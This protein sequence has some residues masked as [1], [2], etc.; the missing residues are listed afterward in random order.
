[1]IN[2]FNY[3]KLYADAP[4][5]W[6]YGF[7]DSATPVLEG[8]NSLHTEVMSYLVFIIIGVLYMILYIIYKFKD[9]VFVHK[10]LTHG[11]LIE[12][13]WTITPAFVLMV[14]AVPSLKLLYLTD[15]VIDPVIT[16]KAIGH[17][18]YWSYEYSDF[19][20]PLQ[21]N[22]VIGF[23]SYMVPESDLNKGE[24]RLLETDNN[25]FLPVD[26]HIRLLLSS[27]DVLH[28]WAVP[29]LGIKMDCVPGRLNQTSMYIKREGHYY[30]QC[31]EICGVQHAFMPIHVHAV[32]QNQYNIELGLLAHDSNF[33]LAETKTPL[34]E[35]IETDKSSQI[36]KT[37]QTLLP[38]TN[39]TTLTEKEQQEVDKVMEMVQERYVEGYAEWK[40]NNS[41]SSNKKV[42]YENSIEAVE[43]GEKHYTIQFIEEEN[44]EFKNIYQFS[45]VFRD[46]FQRE[47]RIW[48][49]EAYHEI[50]ILNKKYSKFIRCYWP[51]FVYKQPFMEQPRWKLYEEKFSDIPEPDPLDMNLLRKAID[52]NLKSNKL[53][54]KKL[55]PTIITT[56]DYLKAVYD[57]Y[58]SFIEYLLHNHYNKLELKD[59]IL[60][61]VEILNS[62]NRL[63]IVYNLLYNP[64]YDLD[65][66]QDFEGISEINENRKNKGF[67]L[68]PG[69]YVEEAYYIL[70]IIR[71]ELIETWYD[72]FCERCFDLDSYYLENDLVLRYSTL[73]LILH[74]TLTFSELHRIVEEKPFDFK[75]YSI[76][77]YFKYLIN[78]KQKNQN[79]HNSIIKDM[80]NIS[81]REALKILDDAILKLK[82]RD[83]SILDENYIH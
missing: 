49:E 29:S 50:D 14:I 22:K 69:I 77:D 60:K 32:S 19:Y 20:S 72:L 71:T 7:Q 47:Q 68:Y 25:L 61:A 73:D 10:Y 15:E 36:I 31:S 1:M 79:L 76:Y 12:I 21:K 2:Y 70:G 46:R 13:V 24:F 48:A 63:A 38:E 16:V 23:D 37:Y 58:G 28:S 67:F 65:L 27:G 75:I 83:F 66:N 52:D 9:A 54:Q 64:N 4:E 34:T 41:S 18:W 56:P 30:G 82:N 51:L 5:P 3:I 45:A 44:L 42:H 17:Q 78:G 39:K 59:A 81:M 43:K 6:Q 26:T 8:I 55:Y 35:T 33:I 40:K 80:E 53:L 62:K 57:T 74:I 11:T